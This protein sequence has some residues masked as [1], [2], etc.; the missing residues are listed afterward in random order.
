MTAIWPEADLER[1]DAC[2]V[3][4]AAERTPLETGLTDRVHGIAPGTWTLVRCR[5]CGCGFLDPR[6]TPESVGRAY[7]GDYITH[8][9]PEREPVPAGALAHA[10]RR[11][12]NGYVNRRYGLR[13]RPASPLG[14]FVPAFPPLRAETDRNF[15]HLS[16][17][18]PGAPLLDIGC[19]NGGA[20]IRLADYGWGAVGHEI[21]PEAAAEARTAGAEVISCPLEALA[22]RHA[23]RYAA[24][25]LSHVIE[26]V[27]DPPSFLATARRLL[28]PDGRIW[29][30]TPNLS[31]S[32]YARYGRDWMALEP[33]RHLVLFTRASLARL[34]AMAG[35]AE[36]AFP[37]P[38]GGAGGLLDSSRALREGRQPEV[39]AP[40]SRLPD[41]VY[42]A[43]PQRAEEL[44]ATAVRGAD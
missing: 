14:R 21:D 11:I 24:V 38:W 40:G 31:S 19:G 28:R 37:T 8:A 9:A 33:P 43:R 2:P 32:G 30:A 15:R 35:F 13:L 42:L 18:E 16:L 36:V 22:D 41:L 26:H 20:V 5:N 17:P 12:R 7:A 25:T 6:P 29:L 3:C 1:V 39:L 44:V 10:R 4:G 27:H 34:L 23:G